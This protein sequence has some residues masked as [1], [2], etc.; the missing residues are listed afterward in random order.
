[1]QI[2]TPPPLAGGGWGEGARPPSGVGGGVTPD[3]HL[4]PLHR[5][6]HRHLAAGG[7]HSAGRRPRLSRPARLRPAGSRFPH[8]PGH[9]PASGR[10]SGDG[11]DPDHR[12]AG[13][14]VRP[15]PRPD[16]DD[17]AKLR[18]HQPDHPPVRPQSQHGF[19][20][21]GRAGRDQR[22]RRHAAGEPSLSAG[23]R[24][25]EPGR[26]ADPDAGAHLRLSPDRRG[27]RRRRHI[28]AAE[29][30]R[31]RRRRPRHRAGRTAPCR[32]RARRSRAPRLRTG[33]PWRTCAPRSPMP[34]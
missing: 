23:L 33:S 11:G 14:P 26:C 12:L 2:R 31:D 22:R 1:M 30:V 34:T 28:V 17:L 13:T 6:P 20:R 3:E 18:G 24:Q 27:Q 21:A 9:H 29:T 15:D 19:R 4:R 8:H 10:Q 25:G 5:P 32:A 16:H 7:R